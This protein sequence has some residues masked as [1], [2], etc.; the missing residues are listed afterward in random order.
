[1]QIT[2]TIPPDRLDP[3]GAQELARILGCDAAALPGVLGRHA[4]A[5][6]SEYL[7]MYRGQKVLK[8]GSD[9]LEYR[10]Y[11]LISIALA[12]RIPDEQFVSALFQT[13]SAE[14]RRLI[15]S[16]LSKYQYQLQEGL[17][18]TMAASM[19]NLAYDR[20]G[21]VYTMVLNNTNIVDELNKLLAAADG[22]LTPVTRRR[23]SVSTCDIRPSSYE[24][25]CKLLGVPPQTDHLGDG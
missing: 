11:L 22:T 2:V 4:E 7:S 13:T 17:R 6:L 25:L 20:E 19:T 3:E 16:V 24:Q 14:S 18:A 10:L 21:G 15:R 8:R 12:G 5:A 9:M 1:M 23:G